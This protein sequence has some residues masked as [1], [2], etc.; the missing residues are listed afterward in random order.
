MN[1]P[2]FRGLVQKLMQSRRWWPIHRDG[3]SILLVRSDV[4]LPGELRPTPDSGYHWWAVGRQAMDEQR[5]DDAA[6]ALERALEA[7][8]RLWPACQ[9]LALVRSAQG[10][11]EA[12]VRTVERCQAIFPDLQ[13][14]ADELLK[15]GRRS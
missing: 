2:A 3:V 12:T 9:E 11:R 5:L 4:T 14:D 7:D 8:P 1:S 6:G 10:D 13:L 15:R